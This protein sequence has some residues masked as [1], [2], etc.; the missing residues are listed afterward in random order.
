MHDAGDRGIAV[1]FPGKGTVSMPLP[2]LRATVRS[3][4]SLL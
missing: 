2:G 4:S 3:M 1:F